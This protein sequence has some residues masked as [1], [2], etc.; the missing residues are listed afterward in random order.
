MKRI[1]SLLLS[2]RLLCLCCGCAMQTV[3]EDQENCF[4]LYYAADLTETPGGDAIASV[5]VDWETLPKEDRQ[6]QALAI[7]ELL[8][9]GCDEEK[10]TSPIPAGTKL[11]SCELNGSV[12]SVD[13]SSLYG[14]LSG[15]QLTIADYCITLS[16]TQLS[17]IHA[18]RIT[19]NGQELSYRDTNR[20]LAGDVLLTST[21]DVV[22]TLTANLWFPDADGKL[23]PE[24][25]LL[26]IYEGESRMGAVMDALL[27]GP[28]TE[29][30]LPL[31][32][33]GFSVLSV[34]VEENTCY[35][36][37]PASD[38]ELLPQE[39]AKQKLLVQGMVNSLCSVEDVQSVQVLT[40]G[41]VVSDLGSVSVAEPLQAK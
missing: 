15:I 16:L 3:G 37:L 1:L 13:F 10:F 20:F 40:D 26:S 4:R 21:E 22:R 27:A 9:G 11:Q 18:V 39:A 5:N 6:A 2:L 36:N 25:R 30:L 17:G 35:L 28:E 19:V 7:M 34:W 31:L 33:E 38:A 41:A 29:D 8:M 12:A 23:V 32:P 24:E 14:Q